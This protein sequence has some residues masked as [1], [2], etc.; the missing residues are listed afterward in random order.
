MTLVLTS[1][2]FQM[3]CCAGEEQIKDVYL[4]ELY[5]FMFKFNNNLLPDNFKDYYKSIKNVH[6]NHTRSS[7]TNFS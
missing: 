2:F 4:Y 5:L 7:E 6:K 3:I 1:Q